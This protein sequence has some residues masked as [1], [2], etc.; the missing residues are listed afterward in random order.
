MMHTARVL[1]PGQ[2]KGFRSKI[3]ESSYRSGLRTVLLGVWAPLAF[4]AVE[5]LLLL[6]AVWAMEP[7]G[8]RTMPAPT[9][10]S[11]ART[12]RRDRERPSERQPN[13]CFLG[14]DV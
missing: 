3:S 6:S 13:A 10:D 12:S 11:V 14:E 8:D 1:P 7:L 9:A 4:S 2:A 5:P